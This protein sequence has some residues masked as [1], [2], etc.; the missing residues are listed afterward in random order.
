MAALGTL[1][2][3]ARVLP[4]VLGVRPRADPPAARPRRRA[5]AG[6]HGGALPAE[7]RRRSATGCPSSST[8]CSS[9]ATTA[10]PEGPTVRVARPAARRGVADATRSAHRPRGHGAAALH[11]GHDRHAEGRG[12][13]ARGGASP[14]TPPA[15]FAL[16]LHPDDVFW[17][18]ADPGWV[19]GTSY[20][21]I[22]PLT[23]GV[24]THRR[25][26]RL[27]RRALVPDLADQRVD[28]L[29]HRADRDPH[30]HAGRRRAGPA[31]STSPRCGSSPAS[32]SRSTPRRW[33]GAPRCSACRSTTT[34]G[35][36]RPAGS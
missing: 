30:A 7:G 3:R 24:T 31:R 9:T 18:T 27:R 11:L 8:C 28:G 13:R 4:A 16:D 15:R 5:G 29:V 33:C 26:G 36:P 19:T 2:H 23:H 6:D 35:R 17:C 34:G 20:G 12:A 10:A 14:T 32:A 21:I 22:A 1:K 25:R